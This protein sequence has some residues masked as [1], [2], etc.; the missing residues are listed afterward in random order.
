ME[1]SMKQRLKI[2][3]E[4]QFDCCFDFDTNTKSRFVRISS[5]RLS[6]FKKLLVVYITLYH[7]E[8]NKNVYFGNFSFY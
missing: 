5:N 4:H 3:K 8:N 1:E 7:K 6:K 2:N